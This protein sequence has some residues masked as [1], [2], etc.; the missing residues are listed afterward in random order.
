MKRDS[1][2]KI[3]VKKIGKCLGLVCL[4]LLVV[5]VSYVGY[6]FATY[7]R[8]EDNLDLEVVTPQNGEVNPLQVN[9]EYTAITY[10]V[11]FGAYTPEY[12][13][14]MDGG[15]YSWAKS[16][17]SVLA[18]VSGAAN[19]TCKKNPDF[20][21]LQ[22][23]DIDG[24]RSYHVDETQIFHEFYPNY[25]ESHARNFDSGFLF[26]P[27]WQPHGKNK[28][29]ICLY[30]KYPIV[31]SLRRSLPI[32]EDFTK[33]VDLDRCYSIS[34]VPVENGRQLAIIVIHMSAYTN[35]DAVHEG[36]VRMLCDDIQKELD[37][38]NYII[39][40]GDYN[41][42]LLA[43]KDTVS[44]LEWAKPFP[45]EKLPKHVS[46]VLD[47]LPKKIVSEM[48]LTARNND[49]PYTKG[50]TYTVTL[51]GFIVSDNIEVLDY[52]VEETGF[53][54][55]DHEPVIMKFRLKDTK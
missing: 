18:T 6:M 3:Y 39:C 43:D 8:M 38:G 32:A 4:V 28:S 37:L 42:D 9:Q 40:G 36:Q 47:K 48:T 23:V 54:Y 30:S 13:F 7:H 29:E 1:S 45:K 16:E 44:A 26:W 49:I 33:I 5:V 21:F 31:D 10:N 46:F 25:Y 52:Q 11:G 22:E 35:S 51:D 50:V 24:T 55:S 27:L 12:T 34:H 20:L 17:E 53:L 41:Q 14:F 2:A 15:K 19:L